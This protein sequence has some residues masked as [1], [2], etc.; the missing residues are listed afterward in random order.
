VCGAHTPTFQRIAAPA[1]ERAATAAAF[2]AARITNVLHYVDNGEQLLDFLYQRH[3]FGGETGAAPRPGL[4]LVNLRLS[5]QA[6]RAALARLKDDP[7]L[8]TIP[9][10]MLTNVPSPPDEDAGAPLAAGVDAVLK[11]P[12][13]LAGLLNTLTSLDR[14]WLEIVELSP[15][16]TTP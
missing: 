5:S 8:S 6:G 11:K 13:T 9:I 2:K 10:V 12:I 7:S 14:Y 15:R 1:G 3:E 16:P 4:I